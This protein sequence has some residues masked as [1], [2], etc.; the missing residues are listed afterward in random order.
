M[1]TTTL[2]VSLMDMAL[3]LAGLIV[4]PWTVWVTVSIFNQRQELAV[5]RQILEEVRRV[6]VL[7]A[8]SA[9]KDGDKRA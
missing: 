4:V 6:A 1:G 7:F 2:Q 8:P 5:L 3:S 9:Q